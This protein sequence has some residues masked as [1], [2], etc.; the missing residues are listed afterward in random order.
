MVNLTGYWL[1]WQYSESH[2]ARSVD[3]TS[4][5]GGIWESSRQDPGAKSSEKDRQREERVEAR[6]D[7]SKGKEMKDLRVENGVSHSTEQPQ[8]RRAAL[9]HLGGWASLPARQLQGPKTHNSQDGVGR[10][11]VSAA[12]EVQGREKKRNLK[13][14]FHWSKPTSTRL[15]LGFCL[16]WEWMRNDSALDTG[17]SSDQ[18]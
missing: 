16:L 3:Q 9:P 12:D 17:S 18:Q 7:D 1:V 15:T 13:P 14:L 4:E 2:V 8:M 5:P 11:K 6:L 10:D